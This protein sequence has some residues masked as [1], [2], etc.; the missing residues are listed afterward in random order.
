MARSGI[1]RRDAETIV[2]IVRELRNF[3]VKNSRPT[4]RACIAIAR[5]LAIKGGHAEWDNPAFLWVCRDVLNTDTAKVTREGEPVMMRKL[6]EVIKKV[7]GR[8]RNRPRNNDRN[9]A[10]R[11]QL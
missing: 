1:G 4:I 3:G 8:R 6:E 10:E 7:C 2:E 5:I 11:E 9:N